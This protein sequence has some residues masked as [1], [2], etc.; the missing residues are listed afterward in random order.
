MSDSVLLCCDFL[1]GRWSV[2]TY[3]PFPFTWA[4]F[5]AG[6]LSS[7]LAFWALPEPQHLSVSLAWLACVRSWHGDDR[8][9][10]PGCRNKSE[11]PLVEPLRGE[12][13]PNTCLKSL[14]IVCYL[15]S[16]LGGRQPPP[17]HVVA[18]WTP[19]D[20]CPLRMGTGLCLGQEACSSGC[21]K[22]RGGSRRGEARGGASLR[23]VG[24]AS[25]D[26]TGVHLKRGQSTLVSVNLRGQGLGPGQGLEC[27]RTQ[28]GASGC[29]DVGRGPAE[30]VGDS[31]VADGHGGLF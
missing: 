2:K 16:W 5:L 31:V 10:A 20:E 4:C 17:L 19:S 30:L 1:E 26:D 12:I 3:Q 14:P 22:R 21:G 23:G 28:R 25:A 29:G 24:K 15:G 7:H 18:H 11:R 27:L 13:T 6:F 8:Y 9:R